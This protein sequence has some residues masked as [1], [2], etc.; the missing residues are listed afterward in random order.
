M[1]ILFPGSYL[2]VESVLDAGHDLWIIQLAQVAC[3]QMVDILPP[4]NK[5]EQQ[6]VV[7]VGSPNNNSALIN[8]SSVSQEKGTAAQGTAETLDACG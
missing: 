8:N 3:P 5:G 6:K 1:G 2:V 4:H 7:V